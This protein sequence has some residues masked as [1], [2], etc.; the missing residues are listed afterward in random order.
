MEVKKIE[1]ID[2]DIKLSFLKTKPK[3]RASETTEFK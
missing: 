3:A 1:N 2:G